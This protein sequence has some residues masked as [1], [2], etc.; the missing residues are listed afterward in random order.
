PRSGPCAGSWA[1][2]GSDLGVRLQGQPRRRVPGALRRAAQTVR[3]TVV[4]MTTHAPSSP[5]PA[6]A[7]PA[8]HLTHPTSAAPAVPR[9]RTLVGLASAFVVIFASGLALS[10]DPQDETMS[11]D[12]VVKQ[13]TTGH[14]TIEVLTGASVVGGAV[15]VFYGAALT[16]ALS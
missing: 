6:A 11:P 14:T 2:A 9:R 1:H 5:V 4:P 13:F 8:G 15:L 16:A 3:A 7:P 12:A 10:K